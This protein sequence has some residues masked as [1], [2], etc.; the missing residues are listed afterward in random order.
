MLAA[1]LAEEKLDQ[2]MKNKGDN[3]TM[4]NGNAEENSNTENSGTDKDRKTDDTQ[5]HGVVN[6]TSP[7]P[8][9]NQASGVPDE[10][11]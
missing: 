11:A 2:E 4:V 5:P 7:E 1:K 10:K 9:D 3:K 8:T 6:G